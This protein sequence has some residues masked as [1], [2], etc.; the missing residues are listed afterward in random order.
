M[1]SKKTWEVYNNLIEL[2]GNEFNI[3]LKV[4]R[5]EFLGKRF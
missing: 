5:E 2:F 3:L 1:E 4:K